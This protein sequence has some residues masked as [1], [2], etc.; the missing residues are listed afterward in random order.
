[1]SQWRYYK[2]LSAKPKNIVRYQK[3]EC[4]QDDFMTYL[5]PRHI[6]NIITIVRIVLV[7]PTVMMILKRQFQWALVLFFIAGVS[8][9]IDG[10]LAKHY[11]WISRIGSLLD[12]IADKLLLT[13]CYLAA[14][15]IGLLPWWLAILVAVRDLVIIVGAV[16]YYFLLHPFEGQPT[17]TS[18][19]NTFCQIL[20]LL[21]TLWQG[22]FQSVP[23][24]WM[25]GLIYLVAATTIVSGIQYVTHWGKQFFREKKIFSD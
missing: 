2:N 5:S 10:F 11:G 17:W 23:P 1:M 19:L 21:T 15:S 4:L 14:A 8:D 24:H 22:G 20:L 9:A 7:W 16:G 12:P 6:P 3:N 25:N 13:S 18:K